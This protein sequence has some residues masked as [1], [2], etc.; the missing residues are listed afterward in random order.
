VGHAVLFRPDGGDAAG[1]TFLVVD[2]NG[3]KGCQAG[4]DLVLRLDGAVAL[5]ALETGVFV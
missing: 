2:M 1:G 4:E 3:E 5:G